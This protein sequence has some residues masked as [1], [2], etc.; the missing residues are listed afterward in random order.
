M[1]ISSGFSHEAIMRFFA[2]PFTLA[3][4]LS[5]ELYVFAY[6]FVFFF[7]F[8]MPFLKQRFSSLWIF[9][10][11]T[12]FAYGLTNML[13][14]QPALPGILILA[15]VS[16][17]LFSSMQ[18]FDVLTAMVG[19][20]SLSVFND[21]ALLIS[22]GHATYLASG[23][24]LVG[25]WSLLLVWGFIAVGTKDKVL[26]LDSI[27]PAFARYISERQ[28]LAQELE[29][30][31]SVQMSF[32][33]KSNP[34]SYRLDIASRCAPA[35]EVGGDY[36]DFIELDKKRL[37][38]A[39]GDVS[40]KGTQAAFYMT[41]T[42]GFLRA[43]TKVSNSPAE[44]LSRVNGLFY[45]NVDRGVFISLVFGIFDL[46]KRSVIVA[47]AGHNPLIVRKARAKKVELVSPVGLALGLDG[48][49]KFSSSI[50]QQR[51]PFQTGDLFVFY[52]DG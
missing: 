14:V 38:V 47:R 40:G 9:L 24:S 17:L 35:Q 48:G 25:I 51:I 15:V 2:Q 45:E 26:D 34:T 7:L 50:E 27:A 30:A 29:I 5:R 20:V 46:E 11:V 36:Y 22:T 32:L 39:V 19:L 28:R 16:I 10:P 3:Q 49:R 4:V 13:D 6:P 33:P 41:L 18:K 31:R 44:V 43:L 21:T 37:G 23:Y 1:P 52:T 12:A 8:L 42:K